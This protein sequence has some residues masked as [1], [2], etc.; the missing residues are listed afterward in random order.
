MRHEADDMEAAPVRAAAHALRDQRRA[1]ARA[2]DEDAT[3]QRSAS[4]SP[5]NTTRNAAVATKPTRQRDAEHG[6]AN[7]HLRNKIV[8]DDQGDA[9][10]DEADRLA[11]DQA[12]P[13]FT[14]VRS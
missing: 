9:A 8:E 1:L 14:H 3:L 12:E 2:D 10:E 11:R 5:M 7:V 4:I 6:A 13:A